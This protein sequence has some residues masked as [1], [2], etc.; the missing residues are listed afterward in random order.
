[1]TLRDTAGC[2]ASIIAQWCSQL[3]VELSKWASSL[4]EKNQIIGFLSPSM[5]EKP[6]Q[7]SFLFRDFS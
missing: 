7:S 4:W 5:V 6:W 2:S 1:M 3:D